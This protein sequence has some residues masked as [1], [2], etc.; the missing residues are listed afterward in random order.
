MTQ[1]S[2]QAG[3]ARARADVALSLQADQIC[4]KLL[5][6]VVVVVGLASTC[7]IG[8]QRGGSRRRAG[9]AGRQHQSWNPV[10]ARPA[11]CPLPLL[12]GPGT[13]DTPRRGARFLGHK[14][15]VHVQRENKWNTQ[16][17][18][19]RDSSS[20]KTHHK[21]YLYMGCTTLCQNTVE[22]TGSDISRYMTN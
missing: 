4:T 17:F 10:V 21:F 5:L 18:G 3:R 19:T 14:I 16:R 7:C 12:L 1:G 15:K 22:L 8:G 6:M 11:R 13:K 2:R 20:D 9:Q